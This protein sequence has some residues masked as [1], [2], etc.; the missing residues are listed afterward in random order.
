MQKVFFFPYILKLQ[1]IPGKF[2]VI[3]VP[4]DISSSFMVTG[5]KEGTKRIQDS[6]G[7]KNQK[8]KKI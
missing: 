8:Y 2:S 4:S 5:E 6:A 3:P 7:I 1:F